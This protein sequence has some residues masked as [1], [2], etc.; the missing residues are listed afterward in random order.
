MDREEQAKR[1]QKIIAKAWVDEAFKQRLLSKPSETLREEG[2]DVPL[3]VEVRAVESTDKV[4]YFVIPPK[5]ES[6]ECDIQE[7]GAREAA[8][9]SCQSFCINCGCVTT[10]G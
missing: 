3:D 9:A 6:D 2:M 5:P 1:V 4:F 10:H 7:C 8:E